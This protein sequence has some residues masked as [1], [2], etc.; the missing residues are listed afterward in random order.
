[1]IAEDIDWNVFHQVLKNW[2]LN[3]QKRLKKWKFNRKKWLTNWKFNLKR[4]IADYNSIP[5]SYNLYPSSFSSPYPFYS[6]SVHSFS[7]L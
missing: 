5:T 7:Q 1:M 3:L 4:I 6:L 2:K